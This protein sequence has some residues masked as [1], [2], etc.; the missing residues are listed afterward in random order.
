MTVTIDLI[1]KNSK[2]WNADDV[3]I[4][5]KNFTSEKINLCCGVEGP[6]C[7]DSKIDDLIFKAIDLYNFDPSQFTISSGNH[8]KS[9]QFNENFNTSATVL[10]N[11][12]SQR[13][14]KESRNTDWDTS[15]TFGIFIGRSNWPRLDIA[16]H[17]HYYHYNTTVMQ[18]H[19]DL[20][21]EWH[22]NNFE[23]E[24]FIF[25]N[26][27]AESIDRICNLLKSLPIRDKEFAY[28]IHH[29]QVDDLPEKYK[30]IFVDIVCET[31]Y[32]G[33]TFHI[34]EK[35]LRP[36]FFKRPFILQAS[37]HFL[38]NFK[39]IGFKTFDSWWDEGYDEDPWDY[40]S[41]AIKEIIDYISTKDTQTLINWHNEMSDT[42]NH[43]YQ[44]LQ[45][46]EHTDWEE[47]NKL[48]NDNCNSLDYE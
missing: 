12:W 16:S 42:L 19:S 33:K 21:N 37:K 20:N 27:N 5:L 11:E 6:C 32:S 26:N 23:L 39:T 43:N 48:L 13:A 9:S 38:Q 36:I 10:Y 29:Y 35:I 47:I 34:S 25:R 2:I 45:D 1:A 17:L 14:N 44:V 28:P 7:V 30:K 24:E 46:L 41:T 31:F 4:H 8:I 22:Q 18:Y 3:L 40:K 15:K